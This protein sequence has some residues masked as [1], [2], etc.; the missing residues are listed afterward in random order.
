MR[1]ESPLNSIRVQ[2]MKNPER[3][4]NSCHME[5]KLDLCFIPIETKT[6]TTLFKG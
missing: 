4:L 5:G 1:M 6:R 2:E 3:R